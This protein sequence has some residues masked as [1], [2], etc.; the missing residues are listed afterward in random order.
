[1]GDGWAGFFGVG[2]RW[3]DRRRAVADLRV[4]FVGRGLV[5]RGLLQHAVLH[6]GLLV[7]VDGRVG[8]V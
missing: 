7:G 1:M 5:R 4:V 3:S 2:G 8:V 6:D